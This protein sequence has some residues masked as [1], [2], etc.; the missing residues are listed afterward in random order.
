MIDRFVE[1]LDK[2]ILDL[3]AFRE[4]FSGEQVELATVSGQEGRKQG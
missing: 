4:E 1:E 2:E 3:Q